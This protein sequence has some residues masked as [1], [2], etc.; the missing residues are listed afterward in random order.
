MPRMIKLTQETDVG[1]RAMLLTVLETDVFVPGDGG[2]S[3]MYRESCD[4]PMLFRETPEEILALIEGEPRGSRIAMVKQELLE[5]C[6][7]YEALAALAATITKAFVALRRKDGSAR[8]IRD[9]VKPCIGDDH[10]WEAIGARRVLGYLG[11]EDL[12]EE[13]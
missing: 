4:D 12:L 8:T 2:G 7:G 5:A 13:E 3:C 11:L 9:Y 1:S 10:A 6:D